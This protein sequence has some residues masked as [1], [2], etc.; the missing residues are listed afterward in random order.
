M[1]IYNC[2]YVWVLYVPTHKFHCAI[3]PLLILLTLLLEHATDMQ[4]WAYLIMQIKIMQS[5][6]IKI[7]IKITWQL[8]LNEASMIILASW[9]CFVFMQWW[10]INLNAVSCKLPIRFT[11]IC[12]WNF[13]MMWNCKPTPICV[14]AIKIWSFW[15]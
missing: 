14:K 3:S 6:S 13:S 1:D 2:I 9:N 7:L 4:F 12:K 10:Q 15:R 8:V 5:D 11:V